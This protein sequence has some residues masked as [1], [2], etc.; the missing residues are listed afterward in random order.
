MRTGVFALFL[1]VSV[2]THAEVEI[3]GIDDHVY[4]GKQPKESDF[5]RLAEM[6]VKTVLDL[7]GGA[8]HK[9]GERKRVEA[10]GMHYISIR[11]S[12]I[13]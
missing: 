13:W 10:E 7:R 1:A 9:P 5:S 2:S 11:L 12:G 3:H 8:I 6:G 4:W